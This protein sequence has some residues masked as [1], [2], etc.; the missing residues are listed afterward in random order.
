MLLEL[1]N[2]EVTVH[3]SPIE[4]FAS[5]SKGTIVEVT[6]KWIKL[7]TP[8]KRRKVIVEFIQIERILKVVLVQNA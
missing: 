8:S 6:D 7:Q 3:Y 1:K 2:K 4:G 5:L